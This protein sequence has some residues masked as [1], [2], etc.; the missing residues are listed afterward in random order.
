[1][2][3]RAASHARMVCEVNI[4]PPNPASLAFHLGR[5]YVEIGSLTQLDGHQTVMLEKLL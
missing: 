4:D 1:M 5:G 2:E 3:Q